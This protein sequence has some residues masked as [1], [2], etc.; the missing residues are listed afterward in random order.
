MNFD[1]RPLFLLL[2]LD[3]KNIRE[4]K[5]FEREEYKRRK[6][7]WL[8][9]SSKLASNVMQCSYRPATS[10]NFIK[11]FASILIRSIKV[12]SKVLKLY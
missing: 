1:M 11:R 5:V 7:V 8:H 2:Y 4:E 9:E 10:L 3:E 6:A 12:S